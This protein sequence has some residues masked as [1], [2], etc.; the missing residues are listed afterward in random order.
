M[1][2]S[3]SLGMGVVAERDS[4]LRSEGEE[5]SSAQIDNVPTHGEASYIGGQGDFNKPRLRLKGLLLRR[6]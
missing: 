1:I 5:M 4:I 2:G 6:W 3:G